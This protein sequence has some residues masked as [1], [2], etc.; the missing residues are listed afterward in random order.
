M[1]GTVHFIEFFTF[2]RILIRS[3]HL[4]YRYS[5]RERNIFKITKLMIELGLSNAKNSSSSSAP[6]EDVSSLASILFPASLY[7]S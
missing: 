7:K 3:C 4:F 2:R 6:S 1:L 5:P